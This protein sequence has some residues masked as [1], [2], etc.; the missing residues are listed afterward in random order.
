[1]SDDYGTAWEALGKAI[2]RAKGKESG[3]IAYDLDFLTVD[4]A[5]KAAEVAAL[6]SISQELSAIRHMGISPEYREH[7]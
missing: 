7:S 2:G 1:M 5:L 6:L 3:S 4:Q